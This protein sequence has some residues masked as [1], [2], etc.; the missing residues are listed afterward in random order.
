MVLKLGTSPIHIINAHNTP[1]L[2][3]Y[4]LSKMLLPERNGLWIRRHVGSR[5]MS[6]ANVR[7][8]D[9][10]NKKIEKQGMKLYS[11]LKV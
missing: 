2:R 6:G 7:N 5:I 1:Q 3:P 10:G 9:K 4:L 8:G 11:V